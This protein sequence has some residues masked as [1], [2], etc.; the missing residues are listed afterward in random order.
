[1]KIAKYGIYFLLIAGLVA[2]GSSTATDD[3]DSA[4]SG[5]LIMD[6]DA[7]SGGAGGSLIKAVETSAVASEILIGVYQITV[8]E[9]DDCTGT[10]VELMSNS[11]ASTSN[12]APD[13]DNCSGA[14][15]DTTGFRDVAD[16]ETL[17]EGEVAAG[18]YNC[19]KIRL[20]DQLV[21]QATLE[22]SDGDAQCTGTNTLD[23]AGTEDVAE[24]GEYCWSTG[25]AGVDVEDL[26]EDRGS[27]TDADSMFPLAEALTVTADATTTSTFTMDN[28]GSIEEPD[29]GEGFYARYES[30]AGGDLECDIP[31]PTMSLE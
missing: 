27:C 14:A 13:E 4:G 29:A 26:G 10:G 12:D 11:D 22:D 7:G 25:N 21:W 20:C 2:C 18:T 6:S 30:D 1:M 19:V 3:S 5:T 28:S 16:G 9:S 23:V 8:Y 17:S 31:A 15:V 24:I